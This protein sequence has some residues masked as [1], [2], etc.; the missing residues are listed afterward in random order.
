MHE[1]YLREFLRCDELPILWREKLG[2]TELAAPDA[3]VYLPPN[4]RPAPI[5]RPA[6][7]DVGIAELNTDDDETVAV[8]DVACTVNA[9]AVVVAVKMPPM[10]VPPLTIDR[11]GTFVVRMTALDKS[12]PPVAS[13]IVPV[14]PVLA[15]I[16]PKYCDPIRSKG[17]FRRPNW[18]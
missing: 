11:I 7:V 10:S 13:A 14:V 3:V 12:V 9:P 18:P 4:V 5:V 16:V 8:P 2:V 17:L 1:S 6:P 15:V